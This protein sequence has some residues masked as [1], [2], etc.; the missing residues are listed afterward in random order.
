MPTS[1][2]GCCE[3]I[4]IKCWKGVWHVVSTQ[5][6]RAAILTCLPPSC[7]SVF[8]PPALSAFPPLLSHASPFTPSSLLSVATPCPGSVPRGFLRAWLC[9]GWWGTWMSQA[10]ARKKPLSS[11]RKGRV[12][13]Q[14]NSFTNDHKRGG[15]CC[16][17][18]SIGLCRPPK[19]ALNPAWEPGK[20]SGSGDP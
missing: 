3:L 17:G 18:G 11:W 9:V 19:E 1:Q 10:L 6:V 12:A 5:E 20:A 8:L 13:G 14:A 15:L 2:C 16:C 4:H 7:P